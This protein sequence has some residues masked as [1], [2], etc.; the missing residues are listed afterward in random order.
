MVQVV[1]ACKATLGF[2]ET[3]FGFANANPQFALLQQVGQ[4]WINPDRIE[5]VPL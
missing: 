4:D 5:L 3:E 1:Q 2:L